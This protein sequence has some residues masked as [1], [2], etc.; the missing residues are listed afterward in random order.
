MDTALPSRDNTMSML[1]V[2]P[3]SA[4]SNFALT[5]QG[6]NAVAKFFLPVDGLLGAPLHAVSQRRT[7]QSRM[8]G[9][10]AQHGAGVVG[11]GLVLV[12]LP[13]HIT[14]SLGTGNKPTK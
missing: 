9:D 4:L 6:T 12:I 8:R 13:I 3:I 5:L 10:M 11:H 1:I 2:L 14:P 7:G